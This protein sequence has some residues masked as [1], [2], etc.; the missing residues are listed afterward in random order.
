M[1][2]E[3]PHT[4]QNP[5]LNSVD[6]FV[7]HFAMRN[8]A[9]PNQDVRVGKT[10]FRQSMFRLLERRR[11]DFEGSI[12]GQ[13]IRDALMNALRVNLPNCF[14]PLFMDVFAPDHDSSLVH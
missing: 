12:Y 1:K 3:E 11:S 7:R 10:G 14:G 4:F 2:Y 5:F 13:T 6:G 9:A 8:M